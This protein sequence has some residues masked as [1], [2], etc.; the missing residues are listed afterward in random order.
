MSGAV[1][2]A[3][4]L[5]PNSRP[6]VKEAT[7]WLPEPVTRFGGGSGDKARADGIVRMREGL[8]ANSLRCALRSR[9][10]YLLR[11]ARSCLAETWLSQETT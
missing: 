11:A 3:S 5:T 8:A 9:G 1:R 2:A 10:C 7:W 4:D 6:T